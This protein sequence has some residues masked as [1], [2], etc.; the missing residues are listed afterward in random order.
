MI[1]TQNYTY[2]QSF[3]PHQ[4]LLD[5]VMRDLLLLS[6]KDFKY[7]ESKNEEHAKTLKE[8]KT[9]LCE[10]GYLTYKQ[11]RFAGSLLKQIF[12]ESPKK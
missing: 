1:Q 3:Y 6:D 5:P 11:L 12:E 7:A 2:L 4:H 8:F 9:K 10:N